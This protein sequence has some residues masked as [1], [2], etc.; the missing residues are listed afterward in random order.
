MKDQS[1][2]VLM[3]PYNLASEL[4]GWSKYTKRTFTAPTAEQKRAFFLG[5]SNPDE[6]CGRLSLRRRDEL[7]RDAFG[8]MIVIKRHPFLNPWCGRVG[9]R[10][11]RI[12]QSA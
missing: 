12:V 2:V 11:E 9:R 4:A 6:D 5:R 7:N 3:F 1:Q 8:F 10:Q